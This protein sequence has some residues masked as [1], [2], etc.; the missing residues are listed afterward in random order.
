MQALGHTFYEKLF[1]SLVISKNCKLVIL[2]TLAV[3]SSSVELT[4]R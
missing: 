4:I 3:I 2:I 1:K